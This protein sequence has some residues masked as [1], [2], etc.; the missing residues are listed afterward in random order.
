MFRE[1]SKRSRV[2]IS[3]V[4]VTPR[5]STY[6]LV[7][8]AAACCYAALGAVL[9]IVPLYVAD[10]LGAGPTVVGLAVG[11]PAITGLLV[12]PLGGRLADRLGPVRPLLAGSALMAVGAIPAVASAS[13]PALLGSRLAVGAGEG[14]MM[15]ATVLWLLRLAEPGRRGRAL[16]HIGLANYAGLAIGSLLAAALGA[17]ADAQAV[18]WTAAILPLVGGCLVLAATTV[19][20]RATGSATRAPRSE[21][22]ALGIGTLLA[23][24]APAGLGLMLVNV[25]YVSILSFGGAVAVAHQTALRPLIVPVFAV[26]VILTRTVGGSLPDRL[27]GRVT[28]VVFAAAEAAGLLLYTLAGSRLLALGALIMLSVGQSLVV[29]GL[30]LLALQHV[31]IGQQGAAAGMFFAWFDAGVG[32]GGPLIGAAAA[33]TGSTGALQA[34]ATLVGVAA[35]IGAFANRHRAARD[36]TRFAAHARDAPKDT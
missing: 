20:D 30:G 5:S 36:R 21:A 9:A 18:L 19:G 17:A 23:L 32:L 12:R 34:A 2:N 33:A 25:G 6:L 35:L 14:L 3:S 22:P 28:V 26:V 29:P 1:A 7:L 8:A 31:P 24:T 27:G 10:R 15:S 13:V 11:A 4:A 16:G